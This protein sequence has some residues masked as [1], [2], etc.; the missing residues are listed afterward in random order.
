M[1]MSLTG[2]IAQQVQARAAQLGPTTGPTELNELLRLLGKW[3]SQLLANTYIAHQ[4]RRVLQGP[5][6]GMEYVTSATEGA[7]MPR[8]LG[9]Y[10]SELHPYIL[11]FA[12]RGLDRIIV[13]GCAEGYY[14]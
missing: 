2:A 4:G 9:T 12:E 7:L 1:L 14:A 3:R 6:A 10:E 11:Q 13:I 5:F 8:L